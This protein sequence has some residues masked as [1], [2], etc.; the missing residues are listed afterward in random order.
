MKRPWTSVRLRRRLRRAAKRVFQY[1][2]EAL[3][4]GLFRFVFARLSLDATSRIGHWL[5]RVPFARPLSLR[6]AER[7]LVAGMPDLDPASRRILARKVTG[8]LGST[9]LEYL[10]TRTLLSEPDR[11]HVMGEMHA[12][13][14]LEAGRGVVFATAHIANPEACRIAIQR[15][16]ASPALYYRPPSNPFVRKGIRE[17]LEAIDAP[18]FGRGLDHPRHMRRYVGAGGVI[19]IL[20]DQRVMGSVRLPFLGR[21][22]RTATGAA[23]LARRTGAAFVPVRCTRMGGKRLTYEVRFEAPI[24]GSDSAQIMI[25]M[26]QRIGQWVMDSPDQWLWVHGRWD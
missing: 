19:L 14:A 2:A 13:R 21:M 8:A 6:K 22:A 11:I 7:N 3:A 9:M 5:G 23:T 1:P 25:E 15:L 16:G 10:H 24:V 18:L 20:V 26:N 17:I 4:F 12:R